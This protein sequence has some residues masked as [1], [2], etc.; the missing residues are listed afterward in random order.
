MS[1]SVWDKLLDVDD[2]LID[3][4]QWEAWKV[5]SCSNLRKPVELNN[6]TAQDPGQDDESRVAI[7]HVSDKNWA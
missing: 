5:E 3:T 6:E 4:D 2:V 1:E 7:V